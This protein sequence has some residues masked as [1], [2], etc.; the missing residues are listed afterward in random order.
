MDKRKA[1]GTASGKIILIGEH[2]VVYGEPS[3]AIPFPET[4]VQ[5]IIY[6]RKGPVTLDCLYYKGILT[7]AP[8]VI[9]GLKQVIKNVTKSFNE[10]LKNFS[11]C[12]ESTIPP[13]RG[14]G[15]SAAVTISTIRALY[16][17]FHR[18]LTHD[19]LLKWADVSE[20]IVH[21]NPSGIDAAVVGGERTLYYIK[22]MPFIPFE[23]NLNAFL[24]VG[25]TGREGQT[26]AAVEGVR[27]LIES[28]PEEGRAFIKELGRLTRIAKTSIETNDSKK[29]G[30]A[31]T[32]AHN[33]LDKLGVSDDK[34]NILVST[35]MNSGA[36]GA[37]LT[38]GGR[39]GCMIAL[40]ANSKEANFI[41]NKL[42]DSGAK[43]TWISRLGDD[44]IDK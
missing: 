4:K 18:P 3:I 28:N 27:Q 6:R 13:E 41:S 26:K 31:M 30:E 22:G 29:L 19:E 5:T 34:L 36:L 39:G 15:S 12:I 43:N 23:F 33:I 32:K 37:K 40:A 8:K 20:K 16:D 17:F 24:V 1:V 14:M 9:A 25:D 21:G 44:L 2:A 42:L 10:E 38:G 7:D 35:A 11:I